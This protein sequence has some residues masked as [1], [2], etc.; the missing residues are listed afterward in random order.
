[1]SYYTTADEKRDK[2]KENIK[3]CLCCLHAILVEGC[4]GSNE[5]TREYIEQMS[6]AY[7]KL[8]E[9]KNLMSS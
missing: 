2:V 9:A 6:Q 1:M 3:E 7:T 5:Y 8:M 4:S